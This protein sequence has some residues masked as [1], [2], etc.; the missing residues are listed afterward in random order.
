MN[1]FVE[2]VSHNTT[3]V[4][5]RTCGF[6]PLGARITTCA[7]GGSDTNAQQSVGVTDGTLQICDTFYQ[8]ASRGKQA[9]ISGELVHCYGWNGSAFTDE[10]VAT[11][12]S[13][14]STEF[15]YNVTTAN[16][17]YQFLVEV[18]G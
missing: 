2:T 3:G 16:V 6:Q 15:K 4:K 10:V 18:W 11:F 9:R 17:S 7:P 5:T 14:T 13:F 8:D 12:D 1:Y